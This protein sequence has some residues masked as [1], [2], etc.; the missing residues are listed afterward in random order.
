MANVIFC[1]QMCPMDC[2]AAVDLVKLIADV[3]KAHPSKCKP[4]WVLSHRKDTPL[5]RVYQ[6]QGLLLKVFDQV[7]VFKAARYANGWPGGS[8]ALWRSTMEDIARLEISEPGILTFEPDCVPL[9]ADWLDRLDGAYANRARPILGHIHQEET[10]DQHVNGNAIWPVD[11]AI[12]WPQV[13]EA[14]PTMA[15]DYWGRN[16]YIREAEDTAL[17]TQWYRRRKLNE[18]EWETIEKHGLRPVLLHGVKD[19]SGRILARKELMQVQCK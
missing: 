19:S 16:F 15:W 17:I 11:L 3:E 7:M 1:L 12:R 18:E 6:C 9:S 4:Q 14:P 13:L 10:I 2:D 5:S 8:N